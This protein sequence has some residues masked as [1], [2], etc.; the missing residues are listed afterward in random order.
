MEN[1]RFIFVMNKVCEKQLKE[2]CSKY[3]LS[4]S[5]AIHYAVNDLY[6]KEFSNEKRIHSCK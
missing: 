3:N 4:T 6:N 2:I 5:R 1:K